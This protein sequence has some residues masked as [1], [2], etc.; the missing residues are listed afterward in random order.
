VDRR[1][2]PVVDLV[3]LGHALFL[4]EDDAAQ[5]AAGGDV[6]GDRDVGRHAK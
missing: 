3:R 5:A 6:V 1:A 4:D 2:V